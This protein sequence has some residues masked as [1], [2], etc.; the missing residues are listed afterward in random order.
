M[1][2]SKEQRSAIEKLADEQLTG[3]EGESQ[4]MKIGQPA[5]SLLISISQFDVDTVVGIA[6]NI[7]RDGYRNS[8]EQISKR[9]ETTI[10]SQSASSSLLG[11]IS[12]KL[13][14]EH[15]SFKF[16]CTVR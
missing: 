15:G 11:T 13:L 4:W 6:K 8:L 7:A 16:Y 3:E 2:L 12:K 10:A 9:V 5:E 14:V 1:R